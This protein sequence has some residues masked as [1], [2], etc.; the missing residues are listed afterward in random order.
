ME[1]LDG[2]Q[3]LGEGGISDVTLHL[4]GPGGEDLGTATTGL[5]GS[6]AFFVNEP[7]AGDYT[8]EVDAAELAAGGTLT[9]LAATTETCTSQGLPRS[10]EL[11]SAQTL[12]RSRRGALPHL[13][14][15]ESLLRT[16]PD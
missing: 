8:V 7:V 13:I 5:D 15:M 1:R 9:G 10:A 14:G 3:D 4:R 2:Q 11:R 12:A 16:P 6:Y